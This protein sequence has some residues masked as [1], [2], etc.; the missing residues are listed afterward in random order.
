MNPLSRVLQTIDLRFIAIALSCFFSLIVIANS[1]IPNDDAFSY[2]R[3]A[4]FFNEQGLNTMLVTY[5]WY[6]Y[7]VLISCL[8]SILPLGLMTSAHLVNMLSYALLVYAFITLA[9]EY[10]PTNTVKFFAAVVILAYPTINEMRYFL[11][12]DFAYWA[13]CLTA[14]IQLIRFNKTGNKVHALGWTLAMTA[15]ILFRLEGLILMAATPFALFMPGKHSIKER[16]SLFITLLF[17]GLC[18]ALITLVLFTLAGI[19]LFEVFNFTYRWYLPLLSE[20][21]GT[22]SGAAESATQGA[23]LSVHISDQVEN[24]TGKGLIVLFAGYLYS[25]ISTVFMTLGPPVFLFLVYG[26]FTGKITLQSESKWPCWFFLA[27]TLLTLFIFLSI[28]QFLTSRY[29]VMPA[30]LLLSLG[31]LILEILYNQA[32]HN[33]RQ[34]LF[35]LAFRICVFYFAADSLVSF[36]YSKNYIKEASN[37]ARDNIALES[38]VQTNSFAVAYFSGL[39]T[40]YDTINPDPADSL[41]SLELQD[42]LVL[43]LPHDDFNTQQALAQNSGLEELARF[44]NKRSDAIIIYRVQH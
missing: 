22:L 25:L 39:I 1:P 14:L 43:D 36:G 31:P 30:L 15:A 34:D 23:N 8:N 28:M 17:F 19:N 4:E 18:V 26:C 7:S 44:T 11:V 37:W 32:Q 42:Y 9:M 21:S 40:E 20:Y 38:A 12:R 10:K 27:S 41:S 5:G 3:A 6:W 24:F 29:A 13:F 2:L 35:R 33:G 16:T